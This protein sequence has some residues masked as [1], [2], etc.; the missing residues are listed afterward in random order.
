MPVCR[1]HRI[2]TVLVGTRVVTY[3]FVIGSCV[4]S[5]QGLSVRRRIGTRLVGSQG[6]TVRGLSVRRRIGTG[7]YQIRRVVTVQVSRTAV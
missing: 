1:C 7:T 6:R 4:V 5:I 3:L 2:S